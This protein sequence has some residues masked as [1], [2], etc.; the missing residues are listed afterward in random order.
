MAAVEFEK[1]I[2]DKHQYFVL[3]SAQI[4]F[5]LES[6]LKQN[7]I[8]YL[9]VESRTKPIV[10]INEKISRKSYKKPIEQLTDISGVRVILYLEEDV[11]K[12]SEIIRNTFNVD[13]ENSSDNTQRLSTDKI[14]YRSTHFVCDIGHDRSNIAEYSSYID[15]KFE[16]QVR[17][18]LQH[19]WA[20][21]THDRVYKLGNKLPENIQ[22]KVNLYSG[23]L[24]VVD[25][26]FSEIV[27]EVNAYRQNLSFETLINIENDRVDS[28]N[29]P[30]YITKICNEN[31]FALEALN[32]AFDYDMLVDELDFFGIETLKELK[33]LLPAN[34]FNNYK[35]HNITTTIPGV[36]RDAMLINNAGRLEQYPHRTWVLGSE[37]DY[38]NDKSYEFYKE[39]L[40]EEAVSQMFD[41]FD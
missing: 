27:K 4:S 37:S 24:E 12:V 17:T 7:N 10:D 35:K 13:A 18:I 6:L 41:Y 40:S 22:R 3:M 15:L 14:G 1:W 38:E 31:D 19:A 16:I 8:Q 21:L 32:N 2:K 33:D 29:I 30:E 34:M 11:N 20:N 23:M 5:V 36:V 26:G 28:I 9:S 39:Y 25:I